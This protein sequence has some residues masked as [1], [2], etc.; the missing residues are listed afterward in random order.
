VK[1]VEPSIIFSDGEWEMTS[2]QWRSP[3][4]LSWLL[5]ESPVREEVVINDRRGRRRV[6]NTASTTQP[7]T[8]QAWNPGVIPGRKA[9]AWDSH[10]AT[11][12]WKSWRT[13]LYAI[14]PRRPAKEI[15]LEDLQATG[16]VR[17]TLLETHQAID[18][19][20][21]GKQVSVRVPDSLAAELPTRDGTC[22]GLK[23]WADPRKSAVAFPQ[24]ISY[25]R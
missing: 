1:H 13:I 10:T 12:A 21:N 19:H 3:E 6:I 4:L 24:M 23:G 7:N 15:V 5:N 8:P 20:R 18:S 14:V 25:D 22:C 2:E 9:V 11:S 16:D 17:V